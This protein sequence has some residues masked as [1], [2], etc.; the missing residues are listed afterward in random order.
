[1][2]WAG[3]DNSVWL[4]LD[5]GAN[6][7]KLRLNM[8]PAPVY[9]LTV[10][11]HFDDLVV[12]TYGRG[13][14]ILDDIGPLRALDAETLAADHA[15]F[16]VRPAYRFQNVQSI[17]TERSH[18]TGRNPRYGADINYMLSEAG[19]SVAIVIEGPG[20]DTIRTL[21]GSSDEG[22]NRVYWDLRHEPTRRARLRTTPPG[23]PWVPLGPEGWRPLRTW[24]LDLNRGQL[25]PLVVPGTYTARITVGDD[26]V[27]RPVEVV[28]DPTTEGTMDDIRAQVALSLQMRDQIN[29]VVDMIDRLEWSRKQLED[30]GE[31]LSGDDEAQAVITEAARLL[32]EAISVEGT[33]YDV[34]LTGA[35]EDAFRSAMRLYGRF[36]A[37]ASD[38]GAMGA[39]FPPTVPQ[40]EVHQVLTDRLSDTKARFDVL[41]NQEVETLN[42]MLRERKLPVIIS[43][44]P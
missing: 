9:W 24:D 4:S 7:N 32:D 12:G 22:M 41:M 5:D 20:G 3:T 1:M 42:A 14:Y 21:R 28:K 23:M 2:L 6:W 19:Q 44:M 18:V 37:L 39:D 26:E 36:S 43:D 8:P 34:N 10:Q 38:L 15:V 11:E 40:Q 25:G 13:F 17:K 16:D 35:R 27:T 29:E 30:L 31:M 33:L